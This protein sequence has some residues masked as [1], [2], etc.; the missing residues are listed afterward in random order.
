MKPEAGARSP[1]SAGRCLSTASR[2]PLPFPLRAAPPPRL[3]RAAR[4]CRRARNRPESRTQRPY[5]SRPSRLR[6]VL[7]VRPAARCWE[8]APL[9]PAPERAQGSAP[10]R[11]RARAYRESPRPRQVP[12]FR[13]SGFD[14]NINRR[15]GGMEGKAVVSRRHT[16]LAR[17]SDSP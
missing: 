17:T 15:D 4:H 7:E 8:G 6:P 13:P 12:P 3:C 16:C 10:S 14:S 9:L 1:V 11:S 2:L 5:P